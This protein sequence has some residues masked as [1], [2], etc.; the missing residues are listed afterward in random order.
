MTDKRYLKRLAVLAVAALATLAAGKMGG[1]AA[2]KDATGDENKDAAKVVAVV[3]KEKITEGDLDRMLELMN[4][5]EKRSY[6]GPEGRKILLD[7]LIKNKVLVAEAERVKLDKDPEVVRDLA[8]ARTRILASTYFERYIAANLGVPEDEVA[9]YYDA[10]KEEFREPPRI[11]LRHILVETPDQA[12]AVL[13]R[14]QAGED[15][16]KVA[17]EVSQDEYTKSQ[18]GLI[19]EVTDEYMPF[20]VGNSADYKNVVFSLPAKTPSESVK[21]DRGYHIFYV[22][23]KKDAGYAPLGLVAGHIRERILLPEA[24]VR[25]YFDAHRDEYVVDEGVLVRQIL[26]KDKTIAADVAA[27]A[28]KGEDFEALVKLYSTDS[29]TKANGGLLGWIRPGGYIQGIGQNA[30]V[31][32]ALFAAAEGDVV[33]P[34]E[35]P[36]GLYV[37]KVDRKRAFRQ[38]EFDE[39]KDRIFSDLADE[40]RRDFFDQAFRELEGKYKVQRYDWARTYDDMPAEELMAEAEGAATAIVA[41]QAYETYALRFPTRA[42]ADKALFMAGFLYA[43]EMKDYA[44]AKDK[45]RALL[46]SYPQSQYAPSAQ[47]MIEH[48]GEED[49]GLPPSLPPGAE[50]PA[51]TGEGDAA[52][53]LKEEQ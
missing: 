40:R 6:E 15:F 43:E 48:M 50:L 44:A 38:M 20:Q 1:D 41:I 24:D 14:L 10:H 3:G 29:P 31:E 13:K 39:V 21:S 8:D 52:D 37:F 53:N 5:M 35:L 12:Q 23:E 4:P 51:S 33:G 18:G 22:D 32:K 46:S 30:D 27:R 11:K 9:R 16:A 17:T 34:M 28:R 25:A 26:V 47:W 45:F 49:A 36:A 2:N 42:D 19:G 7:V